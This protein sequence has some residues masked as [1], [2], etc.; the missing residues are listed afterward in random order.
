MEFKSPGT[1]KIKTA[2]ALSIVVNAAL[3]VTVGYMAIINVPL[4]NDPIIIIN[5]TTPSAQSKSAP[6]TEPNIAALPK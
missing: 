3:L 6:S 1:M 5:H 2:F 4:R